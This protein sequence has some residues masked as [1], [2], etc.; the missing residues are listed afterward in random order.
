MPLVICEM[1]SSSETNTVLKFHGFHPYAHAADSDIVVKQ[2]L[3]LS[4]Q[5]P[6]T[7]SF[8]FRIL[9]TTPKDPASLLPRSTSGKT[10]IRRL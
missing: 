7:S 2:M 9:K 6:I 8:N 1:T 10:R 3:D 4:I 5:I